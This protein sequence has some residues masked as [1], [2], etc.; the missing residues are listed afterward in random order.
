[1]YQV[2]LLIY[3]LILVFAVFLIV[4]YWKTGRND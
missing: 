4:K 1:M 2:K 3:L